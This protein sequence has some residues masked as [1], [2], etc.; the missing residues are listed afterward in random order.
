MNDCVEGE[1]RQAIDWERKS[2][3]ITYPTKVLHSDCVKNSV[4]SIVRNN[5][6]RKWAKVLKTLLY[7]R[8]YLDDKY[9][10]ETKFK[11]INH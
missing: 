1:K 2:L 10:L 9:A 4:I 11:M 7:Q 3:Q 5:P 6:I 8:D